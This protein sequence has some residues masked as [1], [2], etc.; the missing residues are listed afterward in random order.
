LHAGVA[1][2]AGSGV[3]AMD[4]QAT[5]SKKS[6]VPNYSLAVWNLIIRPPR[7]LYHTWQLGP[8]EFTING[9]IAVRRDFKVQGCRGGYLHCSQYFPRR[10]WESEALRKCPVVVYLHGNSSNRLEAATLLGP[11]LQEGISLFC[12]DS[13]GCGLSDGEYVSLG[14]HERDDLAAVLQHLRQSP[15]CGPIGLWGR[16]MGAVTVLM[17]ADRD[18]SLGAICLDS[19]FVTLRQLIEDLAKSMRIVCPLPYLFVAAAHQVIRMRVRALADFDVDDV[20]PLEHA[21]RS[22][23]PAIFMHG[24]RDTFIS[25]K[26]SREIYDAYLGD[27]EYHTI[28]GDHNSER[29]YKDIS[30]AVDF[31]R[32]AF[33]LDQVD[34][35]IIPE[36]VFPDLTGSSDYY[37]GTLLPAQFDPPPASPVPQSAEQTAQIDAVAPLQVMHGCSQGS[38][39]KID[40]NQ[41][42]N[43]KMEE[44][45]QSIDITSTEQRQS[46]SLARSPSDRYSKSIHLINCTAAGILRNTQRRGGRAAQG[47]G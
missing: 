43:D 24:G 2:C 34:M 27:K 18:Q 3:A 28:D 44:T 21:K 39:E 47:G 23:V 4:D 36:D 26:H 37:C 6:D 40:S 33:R 32:R 16:S 45:Q 19:P 17:H 14:W 12:F 31:F 20:V 25:P 42:L 5:L 22:Y 29:S 11:L 41:D 13:A 38:N 1:S 9:V 8:S 46:P 10:D 30:R 35:G 7:A 15:F